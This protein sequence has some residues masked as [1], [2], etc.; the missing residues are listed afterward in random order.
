MLYTIVPFLN[1][2]FKDYH[3]AEFRPNYVLV[4]QCEEWQSSNSLLRVISGL[5]LVLK[6]SKHEIVVLALELLGLMCHGIKTI[7]CYK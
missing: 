4:C 6:S 1:V 5:F 2:S 3:V 7:V